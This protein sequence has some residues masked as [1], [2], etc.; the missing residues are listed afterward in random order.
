MNAKKRKEKN[1]KQNKIKQTMISV[2]K[3]YDGVLQT[4]LFLSCFLLALTDP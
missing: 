2:G 4:N 3:L 1:R